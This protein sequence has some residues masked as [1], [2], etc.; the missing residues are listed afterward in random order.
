[1]FKLS[2]VFVVSFYC[3]NED[4]KCGFDFKLL[5]DKMIKVIHFFE[6]NV[7]SKSTLVNESILASGCSSTL[8]CVDLRYSQLY[9]PI[10]KNSYK[11]GGGP[12]S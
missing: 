2:V 8:D 12:K 4:V 10:T 3:S 1:M 5:K 9:N 11:L 7:I 6:T